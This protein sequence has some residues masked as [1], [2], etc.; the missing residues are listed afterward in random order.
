MR[1]IAPLTIK[2]KGEWFNVPCQ[3]CNFCLRNR[4]LDWSFRLGQEYKHSNTSNFLTLTYD[5]IH[6]PIILDDHNQWYPTLN[7]NDL[8]K[9]HRALRKSQSRTLLGQKKRYKWRKE[10]YQAEKKK[11]KIKYY[12]VGEYGTKNEKTSLSFNHI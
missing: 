7:K 1:C 3:K 11:W 4:Q 8:N 12:S 10:L 9:F 6:V 5:N 2:I